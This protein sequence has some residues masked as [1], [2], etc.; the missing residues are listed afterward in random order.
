[1]WDEKTWR[2]SDTDAPSPVSRHCK[3]LSAAVLRYAEFLE[4]A[5]RYGVLGESAAAFRQ[6]E[7]GGLDAA[8]L[9]AAKIAAFKREK[10]IKA[11][12]EEIMQRRVGRIRSAAFADPCFDGADEDEGP[13]GASQGAED[14][15]DERSARLLQVWNMQWQL[16]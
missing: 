12:L 13:L 15:E 9:R 8:S 2:C 4:V 10:A 11:R 3:A 5:D 1:M 16:C 14:E 7:A 6:E